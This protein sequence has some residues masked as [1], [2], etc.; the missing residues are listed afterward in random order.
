MSECIFQC[1]DNRYEVIE[2]AKA[3]L[4]KATNIETDPDLME[5]L[6]DFLFVCWQMKWLKQYD[7][8]A[9]EA[10]ANDFKEVGE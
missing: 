9:T 3:H 5:H 1:G 2:K 7:D 4:L 6:D 8:N 10:L